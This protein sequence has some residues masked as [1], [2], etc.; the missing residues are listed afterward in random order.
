MKSYRVVFLDK[1]TDTL[2]KSKKYIVILS[3]SFYWFYKDKLDISLSE[4]K[5]V[6][7]SMFDGVVPEGDYSYFV[8]K[9]KDEYY[10][11]AYKDSDIVKKLQELNI[12]PSE[13]KKV[14]PLHLLDITTP[15]DLGDKV[16]LRDGEEIIIAPKELIGFEVKKTDLNS[17]KLP[18]TSLPLKTYSTF[19]SEEHIYTLSIL[20]FIA[21][22]LYAVEAFVHK[23]DLG[24]LNQKEAQIFK[25]YNLPP[26]SIQIRS[27]LNSLEKINKEQLKLREDIDYILRIPLY[28][29][30]YF[31][32][33][34]YGK[35]IVF[36][37]VLNSKS[38]A[39][40]VRDYLK[41]RLVLED[42]VM[43]KNILRVECRR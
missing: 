36:E 8:Q 12:K 43:N 5:K 2:P 31:V 37:I 19:I 28:P 15:L 1:K 7:P 11:F 21:I 35:K 27:I 13:V 23:K 20:L 4:A 10:F 40:K 29:K 38:R 26:T 42:L 33:L 39:A 3:N 24:Y 25:S 22:V 16:A 9:V 41:K 32:S 14:Y 18:K 30:E 6:A 17:L 34:D